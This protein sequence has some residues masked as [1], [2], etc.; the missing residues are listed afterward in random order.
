M[1]AIG[2]K[3]ACSLIAALIILGGLLSINFQRYDVEPEL[4]A[5]ESM[6][7]LPFKVGR[8]Q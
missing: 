4:D 5:T 2:K 7:I 3:F 1:K 6:F 8:D